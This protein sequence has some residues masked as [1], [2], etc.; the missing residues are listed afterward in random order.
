MLS[1]SE[2]FQKRKYLQMKLIPQ[3]T[4]PNISDFLQELD[5]RKDN[6]NRTL[7]WLHS[8]KLISINDISSSVFSLF[9]KYQNI[10]SMPGI[11]ND[12]F[13][14]LI[15]SDKYLIQADTDRSSYWF[16]KLM[17]QIGFNSE[18]NVDK[19]NNVK[20]IL[21]IIKILTGVYLQG[22]ERY[23]CISFLLAYEFASSIDEDEHFAEA[24]GFFICDSFLKIVNINRLVTDVN[25]TKAIFEKMDKRI[26]KI[27][28][29]EYEAMYKMN[30]TSI[31][32]GLKW[33]LLTFAD[34]YPSFFDILLL[35]DQIIVHK[36]I[37]DEYIFELCITHVKQIKFDSDS[38]YIETIQNKR[39]WNVKE[40]IRQTNQVFEHK[41]QIK[42]L[43][44]SIFIVFFVIALYNKIF[45]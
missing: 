24:I 16:Y 5:E 17:D 27:H 6:Y 40:V 29:V 44:L 18:S 12:P 19:I 31:Y 36:D 15:D 37:Y 14:H 32:Y 8:F 2:H 45:N 23:A 41:N 3:P 25:L 33:Q 1:K 4:C 7:A 13:Q 39:D 38:L 22:Y 26:K 21:S 28:P 42:I 43:A 10:L 35:W 34:E 30:V 11:S 20:R 9:N